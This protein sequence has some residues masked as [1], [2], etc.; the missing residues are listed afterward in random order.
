MENRRTF[1]TSLFKGVITTAVAP[2][3]VTHGL[4]LVRKESLYLP[5][6]NIEDVQLYNKL[7]FYLAQMQARNWSEKKE[8]KVIYD[9]PEFTG[10]FHFS[11]D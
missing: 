1:L 9:L 8:R 7:P 2:Q 4:K 5:S 10:P 6:Y 3:I 11:A